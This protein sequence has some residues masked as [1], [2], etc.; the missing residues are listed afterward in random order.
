M[1]EEMVDGK[2]GKKKGGAK[3]YKNLTWT[4]KRQPKKGKICSRFLS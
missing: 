2:K 1:A 3:D 4:V